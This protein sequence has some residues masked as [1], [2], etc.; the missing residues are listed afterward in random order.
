M[1]TLGRAGVVGGGA[2]L[3]RPFI[4]VPFTDADPLWVAGAEAEAEPDDTTPFTLGVVAVAPALCGEDV[5]ASS[6]TRLLLLSAFGFS[7]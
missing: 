7:G 5:V 1:R 6:P 3:A 2:P 4:V